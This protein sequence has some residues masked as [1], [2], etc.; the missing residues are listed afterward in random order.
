MKSGLSQSIQ[1]KQ[2]LAMSQSLQLSIRLLQLNQIEL[3]EEISNLLDSNIMLELDDSDGFEDVSSS[4]TLNTQTTDTN[5]ENNSSEYENNSALDLDSDEMQLDWQESDR[6]FDD[7]NFEITNISDDDNLLETRNAEH[8]SL[9]SFLLEQC[10]FARFSELDSSI[11]EYIIDN[12]NDDGYLA[13]DLKDIWQDLLKQYPEL[14]YE[15]LEVVLKHIQNFDPPGVGA[16]NIQECLLIQIRQLHPKPSWAETAQLILTKCAD[17]LTKLDLKGIQKQLK[18]DEEWLRVVLNQLRR[19]DPKPGQK[20][21]D[22]T[23]SYSPPDVLVQVHKQQLIVKLNPEILPKLRINKEYS[24]IANIPK[25]DSSVLKQHL[26]E[27]QFFIKAVENRFDTLFKVANEIV[28]YQSAFFF[29]GESAI[30]PLQMKMIAEILEVHEST[31]SRAVAGK[32]LFCAHGVYDLKF[33]FSNQMPNNEN[34]D[35]NGE[36]DEDSSAVAIRAALKKLIAEEPKEKPLSDSKLESL[37]KAQGFDVSRRTIA[38]YRG[39]LGILGSTER[40][41]LQ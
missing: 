18:I 7:G 24:Q 30:R 34:G 19:L 38:K 40:K 10:R 4:L 6:D 16:R 3:Q 20:F 17:L 37:L 31:V 32:T 8:E 15:E 11:A 41:Q 33:F 39:I 23:Q 12:I 29:K 13:T 25:S 28:K 21:I 5:P 26:N 35:A 1:Q 27:A 36:N 9:H 14:L 2:T 22:T